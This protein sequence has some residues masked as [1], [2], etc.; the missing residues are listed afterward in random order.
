[1]IRFRRRAWRVEY[2]LGLY[3]A[4][5]FDRWLC[6]IGLHFLWFDFPRDRLA[7]A[8]GREYLDSET[9]WREFL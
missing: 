6:R 7:C 1:M 9:I 2:A 4:A 8:C 5:R 3:G